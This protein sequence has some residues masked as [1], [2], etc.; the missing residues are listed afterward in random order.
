M[1]KKESNS[2]L[3]ISPQ[4]IFEIGLALAQNAVARYLS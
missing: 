3:E 1:S 2:G 4:T